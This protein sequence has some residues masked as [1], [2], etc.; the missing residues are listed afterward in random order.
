M[1]MR[2]TLR[3]M[4]A[5]L[6][7]ILE[8]ADA[9][10]IGA[11]IS[12]SEYAAKLVERIKEAS[13]STAIGAPAVSGQQMGLDP[14]RVAE[15]LDNVVPLDQVEEFEKNCLQSDAFLAEL[16]SSH[17][18]LT[19]ILGEPAAVEPKLREQM[20][21]LIDK[22]VNSPPEPAAASAP[23]KADNNG[24]AAKIPGKGADKSVL[25]TDRTPKPS[26]SEI[27][28]REKPAVPEYLKEEP[29]NRWLMPA[30]A[31]VL[32][33][34]LGTAIYTIGS[35]PG[36][37]N[38]IVQG[39]PNKLEPGKV[40]PGKVEPGKVEPGKVEPGKVEPGKVEPGKVEPGKV[41]PGKVE[42]GKVEPVEPGK[43]EPGKVEP[44]KVEPG[45]VEPGK[46]E[47]GKVEPGKVEPGKVEPGKVEP[48]KVEPGKVEPG[49]VEPGKVE[50]GKVEPGKVEPGKVEPGKVEPGKAIPR[51]AGAKVEVGQYTTA[52]S[53]LL[54]YNAERTDWQRLRPQSVVVAG[55]RLISLPTY[56]ST[57]A[58]NDGVILDV[59]GGT[60]L[61]ME[62]PEA[63]GIPRVR[64][65]SGQMVATSAKPG[66][67][68]IVSFGATNV[69]TT[70]V[71][72]QETAIGF[73]VRARRPIGLDPENA[74]DSP[75]RYDATF[76]VATGQATFDN[77][78]TSL[79]VDKPPTH[80]SLVPL[81]ELGIEEANWIKANPISPLDAQA[82]RVIEPIIA[83]G[84]LV[85]VPL[86][87]LAGN[88][89]A[90]VALLA[91][92][93]LVFVGD[94]EPMLEAIN[95]PDMRPTSRNVVLNQMFEA[96]HMGPE[97]AKQIHATLKTL[98]KDKGDELWRMFWGYTKEQ[99]DRGE[100]ARLVEY[101]DHEDLDFRVLAFSN[102]ESITGLNLL[103]RPEM[104]RGG[105]R[106][107]AV[108]RWQ[109]QLESK[110]IVPK[111]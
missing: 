92:R 28:R 71:G 8:P 72:P 26:D 37:N 88:R 40:E 4:L 103:Y 7:N 77:G 18:V 62:A 52:D 25:T 98:R 41:E 32:V 73:E 9:K 3:T 65:F 110:Q 13:K 70:F 90:E 69:T 38:Q 107:Q 100:A 89:R 34:L 14:N 79:A 96:V 36:N 104:E 19:L 99:L 83:P 111:P 48:G 76:S 55:N 30:A 97:P 101:L 56:R 20:Y 43:V 29:S 15:Y 22:A 33:V 24:A 51:P 61:E 80:G 64:L 47:P 81:K 49:K 94:F 16:A 59:V 87:E 11:K 93:C 91:M 105:P 95:N 109:Q 67:K 58:L 27:R 102:L 23:A 1:A 46:V 78:T 21:T 106:T 53:I 44:G 2:L 50:P 10:D 31:V 6:D 75:V 5:Y 35:G 54:T 84:M 12:E 39:D 60:V 45:K 17:K 74:T 82:K 85:T 57:I 42:P 68:L 66:M 63:D 108:G 86:K